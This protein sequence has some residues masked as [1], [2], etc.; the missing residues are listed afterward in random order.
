MTGMIDIDP[1][2]LSNQERYKLLIGSVLPRPIAFVSSMSPEGVPNLAPFSFF[3]GV[4]SS[5]LIICFSPMRRSSDG[6]KKDTLQNIEATQEFVVHVVTEA[7]AEKMNQTA[8]EY[9]PEVSEFEAVG[10]TPIPSE[11]VKPFRVKESPIQME[12]KLNQIVNL[13]EHIGAGSLVLGEVIQIHI[14]PEIYQDGKII[15]AK[16]KPIARLAGNSYARVTDTFDLERPS[17]PQTM[18][19]GITP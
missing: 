3:T 12:C 16:L 6:G 5:P 18:P 14:S 2:T 4:C 7:M 15:T 11:K 17:L 13:G 19:F 8:A 1:S 10:L 9:P